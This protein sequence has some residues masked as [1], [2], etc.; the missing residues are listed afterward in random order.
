MLAAAMQNVRT[1]YIL[2]PA[3]SMPL[4]GSSVPFV[5]TALAFHWF[6]RERFLREASRVLTDDGKLFIYNN[7]FLGIMRGNPAFSDWSSN[8]Y[9]Q[10]FPTPPRDSRP[11]SEQAVDRAGLA[12]IMGENYENEIEFTPEELVAY[13]ST[14]TNVVANLDQNRESLE[15]TTGWLLDQVSPYFAKSRATF[16]FRTKAW[17]LKKRAV[18]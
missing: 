6:N 17:Y 9:P 16:V 18:L 15:S 3:E 4:P 2:A 7:G 5:T 12:L 1:D 10:R 13:L 14:Q 11:L 8:I